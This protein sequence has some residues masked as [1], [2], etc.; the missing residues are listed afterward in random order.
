MLIETERLVIREYREEDWE[1]VHIYASNPEVTKYTLWGPNSVQE[2][3]EHV[4]TM[5]KS[6]QQKPRLTHE[7]AVTLKAGGIMIG[8]VGLH[9]E[10]TNGEIGYCFNP[11]YWGQGYAVESSKAMLELG[12]T[13]L[14]LHRIYATCRPQNAASERVMLKL[15]MR[16]EGHLREHTLGNK[17]YADSYLYSILEQD[18]NQN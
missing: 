4:Q 15:G 1:S 8:G 9:V 16:K 14:G 7:F 5:L 2:T 17:G 18:Y 11:D 6:Q 12:F 3:K 13:Q 10:K